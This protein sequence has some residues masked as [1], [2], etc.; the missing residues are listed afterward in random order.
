[1]AIILRQDTA[2]NTGKG[3]RLTFAEMDSN[4]EA[5]FYSS[6]LDG[7]DLTLFTTGSV[8]HSI[9]LS[10]I[11]NTATGSSLI[12]AS[13]SGQ[14]LTFEKGDG[15]TFTLDL[16]EVV[17]EI[18]SGSLITSASYASE[19]ITFTK[20]DGTTFDINISDLVT[21][22]ESGSLLKSSSFADGVITFEKGDSTT[23]SI[24]LNSISGSAIVTASYSAEIITFEKG[25][26]TTFDVNIG[27]LVSEL[28]SGSLLATSSFA[29]GIVTF[30]KGDNTTYN[31]D[32][33]SISGS[34]LVTASISNATI[35]FEKGD[36]S[37]FDITVNSPATSSYA[38]TSSYSE[39]TQILNA[40]QNVGGISS[41]DSFAQGSSIEALLRSMLIAYIEPVISSLIIRLDGS[42]ISTATRDVGDLFTCNTSSFSATVDSPNGNYPT[43]ASIT[44]SGAD[45]GTQ[46]IFL[47][48]TIVGSNAFG[49]GSTLN[50][51][52]ASSAGSV[53]FTVN[54]NS[55]TTADTQSTSTS[56][57]FYWRNYLG[58]SST[59]V[60]NNT[61][62]QAV[63][64][65]GTVDSTLDTNK[66]W[67]AT[68]TSANANGSNYTFITYPASYG[69]LSNVIQNGSLPVLTAFTKKGDFT[70]ANTYGSSTTFRVYQSNQP[71]AFAAG[72]TL[73][74]S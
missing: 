24:D 20:G 61:T 51:N 9:N 2:T 70:V 17:T 12:T 66:S 50:I 11:I 16:A 25:D 14:T 32:L 28:E 52:R 26:G 46:Q 65:S 30:T 53:S 44:A 48:N 49:L 45:I 29:N 39:L 71:G 55:Q 62:A 5:F 35:T 42:S 69:D 34:G 73:T 38:F 41:G 60:V 59:S 4:L 40:N 7:T 15:A 18:E 57:A 74:I 43:G 23:Y 36:G 63:V 27:D 58:A 6:S 22:I 67:T 54:T 3:T 33:N 64:T 47:S 1:M 56:F 8:S 31:I 19:I 68:C 13:Y 72:T 37:T 10:G 21:E